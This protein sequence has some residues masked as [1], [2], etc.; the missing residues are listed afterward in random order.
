MQLLSPMRKSEMS[1]EAAPKLVLEELCTVGDPVTVD[2][3]GKKYPSVFRGARETEYVLSQVTSGGGKPL[4]EIL[5]HGCVIVDIPV[6]DGKQQLFEFNAPLMVYFLSDGVVYAFKSFMLR[7]H[8]KP[9]VIALEY[10]VTINKHSLRKSER[11]ELIMPVTATPKRGGS[12]VAGAVI[13]ISANGMKVAFAEPGK[14]QVGEVALLAATLPN[15]VP[16]EGLAGTVRNIRL[17]NGQWH[18]GISFGAAAGPSL[19]PVMDYYL[20]CM[21]YL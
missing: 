4:S 9:A 15:G 21:N 16:V 1:R 5:N 12:P 18:F 17:E 6:I 10:P 19:G 3:K 11:I 2:C 20:Q 14:Y 8:P 13:D 7:V